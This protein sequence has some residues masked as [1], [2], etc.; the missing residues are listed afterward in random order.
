M[1][2]FKQMKLL[3]KVMLAASVAAILFGLY[4]LVSGLLEVSQ[5]IREGNAV[6]ELLAPIIT[7]M[8]EGLVLIIHYYF[9]LGFFRS[10][11]K[12]GVPFTHE[13]AKEVKLLGFEMIF[14][15]LFAWIVSCIAYGGMDSAMGILNKAIYEMVPGFAFVLVSNIMEYGTNK[16]E[17]G[18]RGHQ[19][20]R[21][22][23][24][25][26]PEVIEETKAA[27]IADG[28]VSEEHLSQAD[29]WYE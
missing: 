21:Y 18:H 16:I 15:P 10:A 1:S 17:R 8:T 20:I 9:V 5:L 13:G 27:L 25:H 2:K 3:A 6:R 24:E 26:Y 11:L 12:E 28:T 29:K 19:A 7:E 22:I 4:Q 23:K 14:L